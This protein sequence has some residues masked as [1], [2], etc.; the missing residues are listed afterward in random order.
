M[1]EV[2]ELQKRD[3]EQSS[4]NEEEKKAKIEKIDKDLKEV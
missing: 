3:V 1:K 4:L 2:K